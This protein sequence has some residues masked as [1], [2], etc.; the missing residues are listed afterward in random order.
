MAHLIRVIIVLPEA[1]GS[2]SSNYLLTTFCIS[3][4]GKLQN[5]FRHLPSRGAHTDKQAVLGCSCCCDKTTSPRWFK[6]ER[7]Y[8]CLRFQRARVRGHQDRK[9]GSRE[10]A[11]ALEPYLGACILT[12]KHEAERANWEWHG[13]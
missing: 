13:S 5:L 10:A 3:N 8:W 9:Q 4:S 7:V 2:I 12:H 1:P 11:M 6:E